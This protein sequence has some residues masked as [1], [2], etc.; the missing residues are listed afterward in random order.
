MIPTSWPL[1]STSPFTEP[2][3]TES[4]CAAPASASSHWVIDVY[5]VSTF[6]YHSNIL[7][8]PGTVT[9]KIDGYIYSI[10]TC[11]SYLW[12]DLDAYQWLNTSTKSAKWPIQRAMVA[13]MRRSTTSE[14]LVKSPNFSPRQ[15]SIL[16][17]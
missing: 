2:V 13:L 1:S 3:H 11:A 7:D 12:S 9:F 10:A 6:I 14:L 8:A 17:T 5:K 16:G 15:Y 4:C